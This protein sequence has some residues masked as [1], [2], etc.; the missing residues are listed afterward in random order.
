[1]GPEI[2]SPAQVRAGR[3]RRTIK[4]K[5]RIRFIVAKLAGSCVKAKSA[6][7]R[8]WVCWERGKGEE[9]GSRIEA[10]PFGVVSRAAGRRGSA[11]DSHDYRVGP[12]EGTRW[13]RIHTSVEIGSMSQNAHVINQ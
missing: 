3:R 8:V 10:Q 13:K 4:R 6:L 11:G 1:M 7:K 5:E 2:I 9:A 12:E